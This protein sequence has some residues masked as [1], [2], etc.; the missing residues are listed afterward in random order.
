MTMPIDNE[1][2]TYE[3]VLIYYR[4][5][6][7]RIIEDDHAGNEAASQLLSDVTTLTIVCAVGLMV[8]G[9]LPTQEELADLVHLVAKAIEA[10]EVSIGVRS[11]E[12]N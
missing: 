9:A 4:L 10:W 1:F 12:H 6:W 2:P 11:R 7:Q 5:H 8:K 3:D